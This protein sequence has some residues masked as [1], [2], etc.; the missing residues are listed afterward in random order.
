MNTNQ[1]IK[2]YLDCEGIIPREY[3]EILDLACAAGGNKEKLDFVI[4]AG[5]P[6]QQTEQEFYTRMY[7]NAG[8]A[9]IYDLLKGRTRDALE[10]TL[11]KIAKQNIQGRVLDIGCGPGLEVCLF[12][13]LGANEVIGIDINK[14]LLEEAKKRIEKRNLKNVKAIMGDR[15][16]LA[17]QENYFDFITS[18]CSIVTEGEAYGPDSEIVYSYIIRER[19]KKMGEAL[20]KGGIAFIA[21]PVS[22]GYGEEYQDKLAYNFELAGFSEIFEK[23]QYNRVLEERTFIDIFVAARK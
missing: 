16:K 10:W 6:E 3:D 11:S 7:K 23:T 20:K 18:L 4:K 13:E 1:K 17:F 8:N 15:D 19:I 22:K 21:M 9:P 14:R 2:E 5:Y 12:S